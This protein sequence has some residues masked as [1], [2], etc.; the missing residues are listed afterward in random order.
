MGRIV[1]P[2]KVGRIIDRLE[3]A[4]YEAYA[5]GGCVRD[6]LLGRTPQDWDITTNALPHQVKSL[7]RRTVDTGIAHGTVT[8]LLGADAFEVTTYRIDG[9]YEDMRHPKEV[10]FT[11]LLS[12][13]LRRRD[14]TINA[15]AYSDRGGLVDL[16]GGE[17]DLENAVIRAVGEPEERFGE[18]ALR[19]MRAV[20]F[21]AQLDYGIDPE[22]ASAASRLAKNLKQISAERV[23]MEFVKLLASDHPERLRDAWNMGITGVIL[24][25]FNVMMETPQHNPH[26]MYSV[27]E[28]TI[29]AVCNIKS[30]RYDRDDLEMLR[31]AMFFHDMGKPACRITDSEG[32]DHFGG[33]P[34]VSRNLADRIMRRLKFDNRTR[35]A[36]LSIVLYHDLRPRLNIQGLRKAIN[37]MGLQTAGVFVDVQTADIMAQSDFQREEKKER[38]RITKEFY[39]R[40][41]SDGDPLFIRDLDI[42]GNDLM[43]QG[44]SEGRVIGDILKYLMNLVLER[45]ELNKKDKLLELARSYSPGY[46]RR[47]EE[48]T[49]RHS[50]GAIVY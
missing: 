50:P 18:D 34:E 29:H 38:L 22:T 36:V 23:R 21:G 31:L 9:E 48:M 35:E 24:P 37:L 14:F 25:E 26:H 41:M 3:Q 42:N 49:S 15:M 10:R 6:C 13:D 45:P 32:I 19:I 5:V 40:I 1:I 7:F 2:E 33:H 46:A 4:G 17:A 43:A 16:F 20:R 12:E 44:V 11:G 30:D 28:H 47:A 27:G 39:D 8:V